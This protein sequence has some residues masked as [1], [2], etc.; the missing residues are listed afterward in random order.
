[1]FESGRVNQ[2]VGRWWNSRQGMAR[3][4]IWLYSDGETWL[5]EARAGVKGKIWKRE[6]PSRRHADEII[7]GMLRRTADNDWRDITNLYL[8]RR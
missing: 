7:N 8:P 3:R 4:D 1:M 6:V 2:I 5:I